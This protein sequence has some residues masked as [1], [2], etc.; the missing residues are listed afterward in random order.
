MFQIKQLQMS[1]IFTLKNIKN[2]HP[3][4]LQLK[5]YSGFVPSHIGDSK[6]A[7]RKFYHY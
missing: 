1:Y 2:T 7:E 3:T 4:H 6:T 5:I